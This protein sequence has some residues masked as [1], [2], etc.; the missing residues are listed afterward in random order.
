MGLF[1][2]LI[3]FFRIFSHKWCSKT[4][5]A[6]LKNTLAKNG[7]I[8]FSFWRLQFL[9]QKMRQNV[10]LSREIFKDW[11]KKYYRYLII[12]ASLTKTMKTGRDWVALKALCTV[13]LFKH[14][15]KWDTWDTK[16]LLCIVIFFFIKINNI[17]LMPYIVN[18]DK[19][20]IKQSKFWCP[21]ILNS[22]ISPF[23]YIVSFWN[24]LTLNFYGSHAK[25]GFL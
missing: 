8:W 21:I 10:R 6:M 9:Y 4:Y 25:H 13:V 22:T 24:I 18:F 2:T 23:M 7:V 15:R 14:L 20:I 5:F 1:K 11:R 12:E 19:K 17:C 16:I 3:E